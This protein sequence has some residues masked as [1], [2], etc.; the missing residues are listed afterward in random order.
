MYTYVYISRGAD[1]LRLAPR[2]TG[3]VF[4]ISIQLCIIYLSI[5]LSVYLTM[6]IYLYL[7]LSI[8]LDR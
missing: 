2:S 1:F 6:H 5:C 3:D 7:H 4:Y 8:Y